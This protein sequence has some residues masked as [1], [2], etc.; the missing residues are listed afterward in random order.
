MKS[1]IIEYIITNKK[2]ILSTTTNELIRNIK[3]PQK[4]VIVYT[5]II[6][7]IDAFKELLELIDEESLELLPTERAKR[8]NDLLVPIFNRI[9][10]IQNTD[11]DKDK[12]DAQ[13]KASTIT[14]FVDTSHP[15][16]FFHKQKD[17]IWSLI[18]ESITLKN[19]KLLNDRQFNNLVNDLEKTKNNADELYL[20]IEAVLKT[21]QE[22]LSKGGVGKHAK[23]FQEQ[24]SEHTRSAKTWRNWSIA[25][26][27]ANM[28]FIVA[29]YCFIS[30]SIEES[31]K[32]IE[33]GIMSVLIVSILSYSIVL[34]V[35]SYFAEKH[36]ELINQ[37]KANCLETYNTFID[38]AP[39]DV[40]SSILMHATQTIFSHQSPGFLSKEALNQSPSPIMEIVRSV[41]KSS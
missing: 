6:P 8:L 32:K 7:E 4:G 30:L 24:A 20:K 37:H 19:R 27:I 39:E 15:D 13:Q 18:L 23:R 17:E 38:S 22:E 31:N 40:K 5:E 2:W 26:L 41:T 29:L 12:T 36:N 34:C 1:S 35:R 10:Q 11:K 14:F 25:I 9:H 28:I 16:A 3:T 33:I 21:S